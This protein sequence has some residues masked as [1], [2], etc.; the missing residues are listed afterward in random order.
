MRVL[1][2]GDSLGLPREECPYEA[3]WYYRL[4]EEYPGCDFVQFFSRGLLISKALNDFAVYYEHY[5]ADIVIIQTG[6]CDCSPR[7]INDLKLSVS[8]TKAF[9]YKIGLESIFW[10]IVKHRGRR[11]ECVYTKIDQFASGYHT[12]IQKFK[13]AGA[14]KILVV[15]IG[16]AAPSVIPKNPLMNENVDKYN[17]VIERIS[18]DYVGIVELI[19]P[20]SK[21]DDSMFVDG[22][23]CNPKG[24]E[25][26][27][28]QLSEVFKNLN[29][30]KN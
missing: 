12:L 9:F 5:N 4:K 2:I 29:V 16:H 18:Q 8:L 23:H 11:S 13:D 17:N 22:Y 20:L 14:K 21:V 7:Y 6:I 19:D 27:Y 30:P 15:K 24:M 25:A 10:K 26:V 3:T 1:C 28:S